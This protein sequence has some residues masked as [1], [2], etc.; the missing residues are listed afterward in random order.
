MPSTAAPTI[1]L[2]VLL[3]ASYADMLGFDQ[4]ELSVAAPAT[5]GDILARLRSLPG[6]ERPPAAAPPPRM[7]GPSASSSWASPPLRR[8][9]TSSG[10]WVA[11]R[12][13]GGCPPSHS[14]R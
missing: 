9:V 4:L 1:T 3:F 13:G 6:G 7:C 8:W 12:A 14:V 2:R 10:V 11:C 5:V